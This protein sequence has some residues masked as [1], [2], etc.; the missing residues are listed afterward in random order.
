MATAQLTRLGGL[1]DDWARRVVRQL[2]ADTPYSESLIVQDV[3]LDPA[4]RRACD[5]YCGD[6]SGRYLEA[7]ALTRSL[8]RPLDWEKTQRVARTV[9]A[10]QRPD[11]SFGPDRPTATTD[12]GVAWGN[13]RLLTGLLAFADATK[14]PLHNEVWHAAERLAEHLVT[15]MPGWLDWFADPQNQRLKFSLDFL[16]TLDPLVEWYRRTGDAAT[17]VA[18]KSAAAVIPEPD[19]DFHMH[20][21]LLALR[22]WLELADILGDHDAVDAISERWRRVRAGWMLPHGGVLESLKMPRDINT[23]C[24]GIADWIMLTLRLAAVSGQP[25]LLDIAE[26]SLYNALPHTQRGS[27]H[28]GCETLCADPGLLTFDYP[29][30]AWWCCTFHGLRAVYDAAR[31]A[32]RPAD[33]GLQV[34]L[35]VDSSGMVNGIGYTLTTEYPRDGMA[36]VHVDRPAQV[37]LRIPGTSRIAVLRVDGIAQPVRTAGGYVTVR[38][39]KAV[40]VEFDRALWISSGQVRF[41]T[42]TANCT[43][44]TGPLHGRRGAFFHGPVLLGADAARNDPEN[45][46]RSRRAEIHVRG[47]A[48]GLDPGEEPGTF[49]ATGLGFAGRFGLVLAPLADQI[50]YGRDVSTR[51]EFDEISAVN[52]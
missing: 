4:A 48:F 45:V 25:H 47:D 6:L 2:D 40:T 16:S 37:R 12:H 11:G 49:H 24:C 17:L 32:V 33:D 7:A 44:E 23:E 36:T 51:I 42:P 18:V 38:A 10:A 41:L 22:G 1:L 34:D 9:L 30:E 15:A 28:Y 52:G 20:G 14:G 39:T 27:G 13:G 35:Y 31:A 26:L 29:P 5:D 50:G 46:L 19:G 8:H 43:D 3:V 21:Y